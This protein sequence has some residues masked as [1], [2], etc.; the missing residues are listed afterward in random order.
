[1]PWYLYD[2]SDDST[3]QYCLVYFSREGRCPQEDAEATLDFFSSVK[4]PLLIKFKDLLSKHYFHHFC[5]YTLMSNNRLLQI[6]NREHSVEVL[7]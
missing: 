1:M 5:I 2:Q 6:T 7:T 3:G 4:L